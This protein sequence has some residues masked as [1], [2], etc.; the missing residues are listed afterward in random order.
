[1][2]PFS[3]LLTVH[4]ALERR[5]TLK[6]SGGTLVFTN[7]CFDILHP[8]HLDYLARARALGSALFVGLNSDASVK[9]LKG[10]RRPIN[11]EGDR[12]LMLSGLAST[13]G[14]VI[15][16]EDTPLNIIRL[17]VPDVLVKGGDWRTDDIVGGAEVAAAGGKVMSLPF[18]DGYSTTSIVSRI[19]D[20]GGA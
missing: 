11:L 3:K 10:P 13:D 9:R 20:L 6:E 17:L 2:P 14:V 16:H 7:G 15:F 18:L 1:M 5:A 4:E 19:L 8:G 12:A